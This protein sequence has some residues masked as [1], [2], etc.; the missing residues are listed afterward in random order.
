MTTSIS[1]APSHTAW[2]ISSKRVFSGVCPAGNPVATVNWITE[3]KISTR[4]T[5]FW[6]FPKQKQ[7]WQFCT[8]L[9]LKKVFQKFYFTGAKKNLIYSG[10]WTCNHWVISPMLCLMS[11]KLNL[12]H[13][14][15]DLTR[16]SKAWSCMGLKSLGLISNDRI[17]PLVN[18]WTNNPI[19]AISTP[20]PGNFFRCWKIFESIRCQFCI[21]LPRLSYLRKGWLSHDVIR[22]E[23][24]QTC[25]LFLWVSSGEIQPLSC[26]QITC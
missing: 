2:R 20:T 21:K 6:I 15:T 3:P 19:I 7:S 4:Y 17:T 26:V 1:A 16:I 13:T 25:S 23:R 18:H 9:T 22:F 10:C 8:I 12:V 14:P 11:F 5:F 24:F